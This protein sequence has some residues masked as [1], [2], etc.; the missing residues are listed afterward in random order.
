MI[1]SSPKEPENPNNL[2]L[3][4]KARITLITKRISLLEFQLKR[5]QKEYILMSDYKRDMLHH[6]RIVISFLDR[7]P[8][9]GGSLCGLSAME[10]SRELE[11]FVHEVRDA[12]AGNNDD[13]DADE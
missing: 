6:A 3:E 10:I 5:L 2:S 1:S 8:T 13:E 4:K 12:L 7:L 9:L 11:K